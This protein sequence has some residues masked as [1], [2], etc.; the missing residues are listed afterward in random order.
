MPYNPSKL[1][2]EYP[3]NKDHIALDENL[4]YES[5]RDMLFKFGFDTDNFGKENWNPLGGFI[6]P[7]MNV[8][9]KPNMVNH[10][11]PFNFGMDCLITHGSVI[12]V[13]CDYVIIAL[14]GIGK[15]TIGDAP[16]QGADF[17]KL[18]ELNGTKALL[19]FYNESKKSIDIE[20]V[21]FRQTVAICN[22]KGLIIRT[23][24]Q[25][26]VKFSYVDLG[27]ESYF[28]DL[29]NR[30][31]AISDYPQSKMK[32]Y[33]Q[34]GI[35][36]YLVPQTLLNA[37]VI[38]NIPKPKTH[39]FAGLT[40][41]MKNFIGINS[42]KEN[43]PHHSMGSIQE[44][45]DEYPNKNFIKKLI[46]YLSNLITVLSIKKLFII[47]L[48]LYL[49]RYIL[50]RLVNKNDRIF[51]GGW[52]GNDTIWR[53][54]LDINKIVLYAGKTGKLEKTPQRTIFTICDA[55]ISGELLGPL[56]PSPVPSRCFIAGFNVYA[57]D[58]FLAHLMNFNIKYLLFL[59]KTPPELGFINDK[60]INLLT[61]NDV[62]NNRSILEFETKYNFKPVPGWEILLDK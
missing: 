30:K 16:I 48:P 60:E 44:K 39:R 14:Q 35:H 46:G 53:T 40:G 34:S 2:P 11:H 52:Y 51:K 1:Y 12:R 10:F 28:S 19:D 23:Y 31:Y 8:L 24:Q 62:L 58:R 49:I 26:N 29:D 15:I 20:L 33:H 7:G 43:L 4:V 36:K 38:I 37:D 61:N 17:S 45:G 57:I 18:I 32:E 42:Q 50:I 27:K 22:Q 56:E 47:S 9:L 41:A 21:D 55:V 59:T 6:R 13:I 54:I 5:I 25:D 3:F